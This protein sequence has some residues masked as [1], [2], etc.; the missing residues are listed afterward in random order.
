MSKPSPE[1]AGGVFGYAIGVGSSV[2]LTEL[3]RE[4]MA[5]RFRALGDPTR[6]NILE[7]L[8]Q[9]PAS[10]GE[11]IEHVGGIPALCRSAMARRGPAARAGARSAGRRSRP[12]RDEQVSRVSGPKRLNVFE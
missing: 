10:V 9:S 8:F 2:W 3:A 11:V 12:P 7:R 1:P 4:R 6:L 5:A